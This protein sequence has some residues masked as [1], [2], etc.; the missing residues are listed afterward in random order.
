MVAEVAGTQQPGE[1]G[2]RTLLVAPNGI[3]GLGRVG[4]GLVPR[5]A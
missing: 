1:C 3:V 5:S 2:E 4:G